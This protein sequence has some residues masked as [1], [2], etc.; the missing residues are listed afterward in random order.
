MRSASTVLGGET[1]RVSALVRAVLDSRDEAIGVFDLHARLVYLNAPA[2]AALPDAPDDPG[3][4]GVRGRLLTLGGRSAELR[5]GTAVLGE[6]VSVAPPDS[7]SWAEEERRAISET[8]ARTRGRMGRAASLLGISRT[9]LWRRLKDDR[10]AAAVPSR[11]RR[12]AGPNVS[13]A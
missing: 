7:R 2:R 4:L 8:L 11:R 3:A 9:T 13:T 10:R 12:R 5:I 1:E 6:V